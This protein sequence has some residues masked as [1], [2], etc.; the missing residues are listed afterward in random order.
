MADMCLRLAPLLGVLGSLAT[1]CTVRAFGSP[2]VRKHQALNSESYEV[3]DGWEVTRYG[4]SLP[5]TDVHPLQVQSSMSL[6]L[7]DRHER[8]GLNAFGQSQAPH[9][10]SGRLIL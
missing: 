1:F 5:N 6:N 8:A 4:E 9:Q 7:N 10:S 3:A 2:G